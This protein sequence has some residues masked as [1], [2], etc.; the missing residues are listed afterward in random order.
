[1]LHKREFYIPAGALKVQAKDCAA[2]AYLT[3]NKK[4]I[5]YALGFLGKA[6]KP[7]FNYRFK[8]A[9]RRAEYIAEA[10]ASQKAREERRE[11]NRIERNK[12]HTLKTGDILY[13]SWGYDQTNIDFYQ[14]VDATEKTV[15]IREIASETV[16][17]NKNMDY[18]AAV[19]D[20]FIGAP[21][22]KKAN[23][24]NSLYLTSYSRASLWDGKPKYQTASGWGH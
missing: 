21:E 20:S 19:K 15:T 24:E 22:R 11:A 5:P 7:S 9:E 23:S 18:V 6:Q 8:T 3:E 13:S 16:S 17:N 4:G 12:P 14:V 10:F 2:V 1:M